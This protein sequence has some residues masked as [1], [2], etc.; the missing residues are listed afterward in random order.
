MNGAGVIEGF[1]ILFPGAHNRVINISGADVA[2]KIIHQLNGNAGIYP[3]VNMGHHV[4]YRFLA[5]VAIF[6]IKPE[7]FPNKRR[8]VRN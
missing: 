8:A 2:V 6:L 3:L 1:Y 4:Y 7:F 5:D